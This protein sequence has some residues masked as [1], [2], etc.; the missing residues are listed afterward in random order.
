MSD[1]PANDPE[2]IEAI[3]RKREEARRILAAR[4]GRNAPEGTPAGAPEVEQ[5]PKVPKAPAKKAAPKPKKAS[6]KG[7]A[8]SRIVDEPERSKELDLPPSEQRMPVPADETEAMEEE[9][10]KRKAKPKKAPKKARLEDPDESIA[11]ARERFAEA[12]E[13]AQKALRDLA[14]QAE[15]DK[16]EAAALAQ[17]AEEARKLEQDRVERERDE[18]NARKAAELNRIAEEE[19]RERRELQRRA[20]DEV[21]KKMEIDKRIKEERE[22]LKKL[23]EEAEALRVKAIQLEVKSMKKKGK[24]LE[25]E[26]SWSEE[27][28]EVMHEQHVNRVEQNVA[29]DEIVR[30]VRLE[31]EAALRMQEAADRAQKIAGYKAKRD[32]VG[33]SAR[34]LKSTRV[35]EDFLKTSKA[36]IAKQRTEKIA[37]RFPDR[38]SIGSFL[39]LMRNAPQFLP[40]FDYDV[41]SGV[42]RTRGFLA[43]IATLISDNIKH[44]PRWRWETKIINSARSIAEFIPDFNTPTSSA[45]YKKNRVCLVVEDNVESSTIY[46]A[47]VAE[48]PAHRIAPIPFNTRSILGATA[49][50]SLTVCNRFLFHFDSVLGDINPVISAVSALWYYIQMYPLEIEEEQRKRRTSIRIYIKIAFASD[51]DIARLHKWLRQ[52]NGMHPYFS[53]GTPYY[54]LS[55]HEITP[56]LNSLIWDSLRQGEKHDVLEDSMDLGIVSV[57][58]NFFGIEVMAPLVYSDFNIPRCMLWLISQHQGM[59]YRTASDYVSRPLI[60]NF[61]DSAMATYSGLKFYHPKKEDDSIF[62]VW[63]MRQII[64]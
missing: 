41:G 25:P 46:T 9:P 59:Y 22:R 50:K 11:A 12:Q 37:P 27:V 57:V 38:E 26:S 1:D 55:V 35:W 39:H 62:R 3:A 29:R 18:R 13:D 23:E 64:S 36:E 45:D 60:K 14:A 15:R 54:Q 47:V 20:E 30:D 40:Q 34:P 42:E 44:Y 17:K 48:V 56:S 33:V 28:E 58:E 32:T 52:D 21:I 6:K 19:E 43:E 49:E 31:K 53:E 61:D 24:P 2:R 63:S 51:V 4:K 5:L 10:L 16:R 7:S 8:K